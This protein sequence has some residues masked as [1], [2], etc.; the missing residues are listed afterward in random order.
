MPKLARL[1]CST[2]AKAGANSA[3]L[4]HS[5][6]PIPPPPAVLFSITGYPMRSAASTASPADA[7]R[8]VPGSSGTPFAAAISRAVCFKPK[9]R[10]CSGVGP[11]NTT[12]RAAHASAKAAFSLRNP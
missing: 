9:A 6:M 5:R 3:S 8:S 10:I 12:P 1:K 7:S 4:R 2:A 11:M